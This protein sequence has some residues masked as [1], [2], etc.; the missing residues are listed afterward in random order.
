LYPG[1]IFRKAIPQ[2]KPGP[3][4]FPVE[5][6]VF[7][8]HPKT[9]KKGGRSLEVHPSCDNVKNKEHKG[10]KK[11]IHHNGE[12]SA[13]SCRNIKPVSGNKVPDEKTK[14]GQPEYLPFSIVGLFHPDM[15]F[16]VQERN[17]CEKQQ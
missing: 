15:M 5:V 4:K 8:D 13:K 16:Y 10:H 17:K 14:I 11:G 6:K 2:V 1:S 9:N 7:K 12:N 3:G